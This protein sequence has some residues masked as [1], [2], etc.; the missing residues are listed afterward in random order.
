[1]MPLPIFARGIVASGD[2]DSS[3]LLIKSEYIH[4]NQI[5]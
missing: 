3:T 1:M 2:F 5:A 4:E